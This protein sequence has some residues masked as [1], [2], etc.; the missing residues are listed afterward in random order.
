MQTDQ[1]SVIPKAS[2]TILV[3]QMFKIHFNPKLSLYLICGFIAFTV[4]GT[5]SHEGGHFVMAKYLGYEARMNYGYTFWEEKTSDQGTTAQKEKDSFWITLAGPLQTM[6]TGTIGLL[7][8]VNQRKN[9]KEAGKLS[10]KQWLLFFL[11]LF[12]LRQVFN[13]AGGMVVYLFSGSFPVTNDEVE[14]AGSL[15]WP[16]ISISLATALTGSCICLYLFF[17]VIPPNQRFTFISSAL[18]GGLAGFFLWLRLLGPVI[19]P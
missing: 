15:F 18:I 17:R 5:L 11:S 1:G 19:M 9:I 4:I 13:F 8:I 2:F 7:L 12:W 16:N 3:V 14:L 6:I 10:L